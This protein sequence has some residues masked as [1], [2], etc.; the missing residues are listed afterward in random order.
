MI[1]L[2]VQHVARLFGAD[3][4]FKN[5]DLN[6]QENSR[7]ALV[8][9]NGVGKST[10]LKIIMEQQPADQ[11]EI[12]KTKNLTIGYL[13]QD[14]GLASTNTIYKEMLQVF[15]PL[16]K[17][18]QKIHQ[19]EQQIASASQSQTAP[20]KEYQ[21]LLAQYDQLQHDFKEKNGYGYQAEI[22]SVLHGFKFNEEDYDKK[23]TSLSGGQ[24]TRLA[25]AKL[26]LEKRDLLILD[27]PTNHLDIETLN[28][29]ENYLQ[30]YTGALLLVSHDRYFLDK[31]AHDVYEL[32][33]TA[34]VHYSGNYS[35]YINKKKLRLQQQ[36][37][38]YEKQQEKID[39]L[40]DFVKKNIVRASTTKRAQSRRKQLEKIDRLEKPK[41]Q[42]K[43]PRFSFTAE[44]SSG[45][46][47]LSVKQAYI[48][49]QK[50]P[51]AGPIN[52]EL[53]QKQIMAIV[54]P[55]GVGKSTLL[56]SILGKIPFISG[57]SRFG[58]QVDPGYY[59][60][61]LHNLTADKSVLNEVWDDHPTMPEK[62]IR[63]I[64]GSFLFRGSD[65]AKIVSQLSGGEKARLL[66]T[67]L[68]LNHH[69]LLLFDEPTNHLDIESK[70]VLEQAL[71]DFDGTVLFV[72]HDRYFIN[73][74]ASQVL[75]L[76][77]QG[78]QLF[79]GD[80]DYYIAKKAEQQLL[81]AQAAE[82]TATTPTNQAKQPTIPAD[83]QERK[84]QQR[85]KR[86][87]ERTVAAL[88]KELEELETAADAIQQAMAESENYTD[89]V[90]IKKLQTQLT[91]NQQTQQQIESKWETAAAELEKLE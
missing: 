6:I 13:A 1:L 51:L 62:D 48:G 50:K 27:E 9:R 66:L 37:K 69:N 10:L 7:I 78:G 82:K 88:E 18:E 79:L 84:Q 46:L 61:E 45:N 65:V 60:Q 25:L 64:L 44:H 73:K 81:A 19:L 28:W 91:D 5:I 80:Y 4:L 24:K 32:T 31:I 87:L 55:N 23:I 56:K 86:K 52:F 36:E 47:V 70:E 59:D 53:R 17:M 57:S 89:P 20:T 12:T 71:L 16:R 29:L 72:S 54:G 75:E 33:P 77:A 40:E 85:E 35:A 22:R 74:V 67:K 3:V 42:Q 49:Y 39:K 30:G 34:A 2:Q 41:S 68:A 76:S 83:Y 21:R 8:G 14:T 26:L 43:G 90:K 15:E 11:G 63:S 58:A 38:A